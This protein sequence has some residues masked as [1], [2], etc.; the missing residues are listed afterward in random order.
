MATL[1]V[2]R[3]G[4]WALAERDH[5]I[6]THAELVALGYT[7]SAIKH[8]LRTGKLHRQAR[9]V[10]S[11]GTPHITRLGELMVAIKQC[12]P[13][14]VLSHLTAAVRW[15]IWRLEPAA[16]HLTVPPDRNPRPSGIRVHRRELPDGA[17]TLHE[18]LPIT[19]VL[20][21]LVD[22]APNRSRPELE[23]MINQADARELLRAD[24]LHGAVRGR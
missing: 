24:R 22:C 2:Q 16:I 3:G 15:T 11:V 21:T 6:V 23:R 9:S 8:R 10:Y 12:G 20:Q 18:R 5:G 14:S 17:R 4:V 1:N 19:T 7:A 13:G